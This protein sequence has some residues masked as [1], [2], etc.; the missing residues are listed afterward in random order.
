MNFRKN[1]W[2]YA[3]SALL[4][5]AVVA[6]V[7]AVARTNDQPASGDK[8]AIVT[9]S[10]VLYDFVRQIAGD[11]VE[12]KTLLPPGADLHDFEPS[13]KQVA[14][15]QN[16]DIFISAGTER[17]VTQIAQD[18]SGAAVNVSEGIAIHGVHEGAHEDSHDAEHHD[19]PSDEHA[20]DHEE[21]T[22]DPHFWLDPVLA[23]QAIATI[24]E[25]LAQADPANNQSYEA[26]AAAY[27]QQLETLDQS[28]KQAL[29][30]C[31][32]DTIVVSHNAYSYLAE[33]YSLQ[34]EALSGT[35]HDAEPSA[36]RLAEISKL[37]RAQGIRHVLTEPLAGTAIADTI[38][39]ETGAQILTLD[40]IE[41][42]QS[43]DEQSSKTYLQ[44]QQQNIDSLS[45]ALAC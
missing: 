21:V 28:F 2:K 40:P 35:L 11:A 38:A 6:T 5:V 23:K 42:V 15:A 31:R 19:E 12:V 36:Q 10:F 3:I 43:Q 30:A 16:A 41:G 27:V 25:A 8:K 45:A 29:S 1:I 4:L 13:A 22:H 44:I 14:D 32:L 39:N 7:W 33:R 24:A 9:T 17:W 20:H 34:V 18:F 37:M 26:N